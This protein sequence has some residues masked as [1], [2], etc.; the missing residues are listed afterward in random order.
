MCA[1]EGALLCYLLILPSAPRLCAATRS[2]SV[3]RGGTAC[4]A[5][6]ADMETG[7][8]VLAEVPMCA[9]G[10]LCLVRVRMRG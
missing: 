7:S 9:M 10:N 3:L 6:L 8:Q 4:G 1:E 5:C 2:E